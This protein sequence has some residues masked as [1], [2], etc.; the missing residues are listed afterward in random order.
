MD[1]TL[2]KWYNN[3]KKL[4]EEEIYTLFNIAVVVIFLLIMFK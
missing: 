3:M 4:N 2:N 1:Y